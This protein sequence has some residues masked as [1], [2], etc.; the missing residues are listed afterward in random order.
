[1]NNNLEIEV[2]YFKGCPNHK[3]AVEQVRK[4]LQAE[5]I[6]G[7]V[8][9]IEVRDAAM[10]AETRFIGSPSVRVNGVDVEEAAREAESFGFGCRTYF[11]D[12][13]RSGL[14]SVELIRK[15]LVNAMPV[16]NSWEQTSGS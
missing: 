8:N 9:E 10:A 16:G 11:E 14:P 5:A 4:A 2:L 15:A 12:N 13:R 1:M 3:P 6:A 7:S